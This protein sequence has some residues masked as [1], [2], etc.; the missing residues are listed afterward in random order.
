[1]AGA[2]VRVATDV[3]GTFTDLVYFETDLMRQIR[4]ALREQETPHAYPIGLTSTERKLCASKSTR[5]R[6]SGRHTIT[7]DQL[8]G[9]R[10][11]RRLELLARMVGL[12]R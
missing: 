7:V 9:G 4:P 8:C 10:P 11:L 6:L 12:I 2:N 1:M 3:G 5:G